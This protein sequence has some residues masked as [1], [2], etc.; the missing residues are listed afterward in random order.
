MNV[1]GPKSTLA[2]KITRF[3]SKALHMQCF[4]YQLKLSV[5]N[6]FKFITVHNLMDRIR[7]IK[8]FFNYSET[9]EQFL[10]K[11]VGLLKLKDFLLR[12]LQDVCR[13]R[14]VSRIFALETFLEFYEALVKTSEEIF[15]KGNLIKIL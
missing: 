10:E 3:N 7:K 12:K 11:F 2:S 13:T 9:R 14:W 4:K 8:E 5:A 1:A 15:Q 6:T